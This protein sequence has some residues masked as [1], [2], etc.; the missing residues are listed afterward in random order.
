MEQP[1]A[2]YFFQYLPPW[3][4]DVF[5]EMARHYQLTLVFWNTDRVGFMY[6][7][8]ELLQLLNPDIEVIFLQSGISAGTH[9]VRIGITKIICHRKPRVVFC[10]EYAPIS[11]QCV[12][13]KLM[14]TCKFKL[15]ITTSDNV[16]MASKA[17]WPKR[18]ARRLILRSAD[19]LILYS[20]QVQE[21]YQKQFPFIKT[22]VC[23]NIQN[24]KTLL[25]YRELFAP[26]QKQYQAQYRLDGCNI[27]LYVGRLTYVKGLDLLLTAFA[28]IRHERWR[29]VL[30]GEGE[31][32]DSLRRFAIDLGIADNV[33]FA[34]FCS[35]QYLYAWYDLANCFVLPSRYE[36]YGAVVNEALVYGCPVLASKYIGA[37]DLI[38]DGNGMIFDPNNQGEFENTLSRAMQQYSCIEEIRENRMPYSF[39]ECV[40][41][42]M[43]I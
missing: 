36:P 32:R 13:I 6:N 14:G 11:M 1:V 40:S 26:I 3:R 42:Y 16:Q 8:D 9:S 18:V 21:W 24:P 37:L 41:V 30:V 38:N 33:A 23:P 25:A 29:I 20:K 17:N 19:K 2:I 7:R 12:L 34:D 5:N 4:I 31:E 35:S 10:H 15:V 27:L 39:E 28:H 22:A 43:Q